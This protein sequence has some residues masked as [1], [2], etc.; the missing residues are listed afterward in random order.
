MLAYIRMVNDP[1]SRPINTN[2]KEG[3]A[4]PPA[5]KPTTLADLMHGLGHTWDEA[6][7]S[8]TIL[9]RTT[10]KAKE[11]AK[12]KE[13]MGKPMALRL[14]YSTRL[15]EASQELLLFSSTPISKDPKD[16]FDCHICNP[17]LSAM[18]VNRTPNKGLSITVPLQPLM[19][20][21]SWGKIRTDG[22]FSPEVLK[23]GPK[24]DG[25][26]FKDR[27]GNQG[28]YST[29]ATI[30]SIHTNKFNA[31]GKYVSESDSIG[32]YS[33]DQRQT[34]DVCRKSSTTWTLNPNDLNNGHFGVTS[35]TI[36]TALDHGVTEQT[37]TT[38]RLKFNGTRYVPFDSTTEATTQEVHPTAVQAPHAAPTPETGPRPLPVSSNN[39]LE[40][41]LVAIVKRQLKSGATLTKSEHAEFWRLLSQLSADEQARFKSFTKANLAGASKHHLALIESALI[42]AKH[43][44]MV[45]TEE[46]I[47]STE[48]TRRVFLTTLPA[49]LSSTQRDEAIREYEAKRMVADKNND[50]FLRSAAAG[51]P[52]KVS[53]DRFVATDIESLRSYAVPIQQS[54][55]R[56]D[57]L[58]NPLWTEEAR[59]EQ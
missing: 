4:T 39:G 26:L 3:K 35:R 9:Y 59:S 22:D 36:T 18:V 54:M 51:R 28:E 15:S 44:K 14:I 34:G 7:R 33:C 12:L 52:H 27:D 40:Y 20:T 11:L 45:K 49:T 37:T 56:L 47:A 46:L 13:Y 21:G 16:V 38:G 32:S 58:L 57:R 31:V 5:T 29:D 25:F 55:I 30:Y 10:P 41:Q 17:L 53:T 43:G 23:L 2:S 19:F 48:E 6:S 50:E 8:G 1:T 42:S 24:I